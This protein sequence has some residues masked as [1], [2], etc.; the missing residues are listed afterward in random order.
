MTIKALG[1]H[2]LVKV[3]QAEE[4]SEGGIVLVHQTRQAEQR[5]AEIG[6][7]VDVGPT[8]WKADGLGGVPWAQVGDQ[9]FFAKY[10]GKWVKEDKEEEDEV[11]ILLDTDI[12]AKVEA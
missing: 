1:H 12:V 6:T 5:G 7:V 10:A 4:V 11:L 8:A 3:E 9:V 2:V